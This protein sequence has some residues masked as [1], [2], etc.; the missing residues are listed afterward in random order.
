M[1]LRP[2]YGNN[3]KTHILTAA[4]AALLGCAALPA[5]AG[6][7][8]QDGVTF[9]STWS[10][11][12]LTLE[13]DAANPTGAW[14][15]ATSMSALGIGNIGNYAG[16][17]VNGAPASAASWI[18]SSD[19]LS[20]KGCTTDTNGQDG[21]RLCYFGS[22]IALTDGMMFS[23]TFN[24]NDVTATDPHVK[25]QFLD[26]SNKKIG[27]LLSLTLLP[28]TDLVTLQ[29]QPLGFLAADVPEP[30]DLALLAGGLGALG[31]ARRRRARKA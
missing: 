7:L 14:T 20:G 15:G 22:A 18:T 31:L 6:L 4:L 13:I 17:T 23:F 24:G 21:S 27:S 5:R 8:T 1:A 2:I 28:S 26:D 12:T 30:H 3:M 11:S 10:G 19:E 29:G 16:V 25:V 9:K